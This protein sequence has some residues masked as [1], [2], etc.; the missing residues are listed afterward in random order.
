MP[1]FDEGARVQ[2]VID[3]A[4]RSVE[5]MKWVEVEKAVVT[6]AGSGVGRA[7]ALGLAEKGWSIAVL[8]RRAEA[9][10]ETRRLAGGNTS[11]IVIHRC[12]VGDAA[13]VAAVSQRILEEFGEVEVLVNAAGT[14][15]P[16]RALSV[17]TLDDY[18]A[19]IA[20]NLNGAFYCV[21]AF[22]PQ[23]RVGAGAQS[24]T[25]FPKQRSRRRQKLVLHM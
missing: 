15:T 2:A 1:D 20:A 17:L 12:D 7:V 10:E 9:L 14:N 23:M 21:Q 19:M 3:A 18:H 13:A 25:L 8:G 11:H 22:L 24:S 6:G 16:Q 4:T 5:G